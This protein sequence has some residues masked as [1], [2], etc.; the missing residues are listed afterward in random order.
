MHGQ[1]SNRWQELSGR[2]ITWSFGHVVTWSRG[3][4]VTWS[5]G[6]VV[7]CHVVMTGFLSKHEVNCSQQALYGYIFASNE[8]MAYGQNSGYRGSGEINDRPSI[9]WVRAVTDS[10]IR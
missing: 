9:D 3:R 2:E 7:T 5:L 6:Y 1:V 4:L 8:E 10:L